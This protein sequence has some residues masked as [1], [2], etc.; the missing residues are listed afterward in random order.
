MLN[1]W[2]GQG[3]LVKDIE[4][5][6]TAGD[7]PVA[8]FTIACD[9]DYKP[10]DGE[11]QADFIDVVAWRGTAEFAS[12]YFHKGDMMIIDGRL[13]TRT[14]EDRNG[15]TRKAT[16]IIASSLNFGGGKKSDG[17]MASQMSETMAEADRNR[18]QDGDGFM[19]VP[20]EI[21]E[22]LPFM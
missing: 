10:R 14:Y 6:Y 21:D 2:S 8:S 9:R 16:E 17:K 3:R 12:R 5:K 4:L 7:T 22:E 11:R 19:T 20:P 13:Q 1:R 18:S 15:I